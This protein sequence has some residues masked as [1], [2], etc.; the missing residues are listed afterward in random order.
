MQLP[1][2]FCPPFHLSLT[3]ASGH[4]WSAFEPVLPLRKRGCGRHLQAPPISSLR[5]YLFTCNFYCCSQ[6]RAA[7]EKSSPCPCLITHVRR[8]ADLHASQISQCIDGVQQQLIV[9]CRV[10]LCRRYSQAQAVLALHNHRKRRLRL[11]RVLTPC[12]QPSHMD[13]TRELRRE[14][15]SYAAFAAACQ[16]GLQCGRNAATAIKTQ[17]S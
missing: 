3:P 15:R 6:T 1:N 9:L 11:Y 5:M 16:R 12:N 13:I 17:S 7:P 10:I 4:L 8:A 14:G 2:V